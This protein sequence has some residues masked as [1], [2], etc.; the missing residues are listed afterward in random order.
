MSFWIFG[1]KQRGRRNL[2]SVNLPFVAIF[3]L[4]LFLILACLSVIRGCAF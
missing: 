4:F 3:S 1:K 2:Y